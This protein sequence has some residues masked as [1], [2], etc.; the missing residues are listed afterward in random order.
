MPHPAKLMEVD[1]SF[2]LFSCPTS[3]PCSPHEKLCLFFLPKV[4]SFLIQYLV[5][6]FPWCEGSGCQTELRLRL[7]A[8]PQGVQSL[9]WRQENVRRL[10]FSPQLS[11]PPSQ[12]PTTYQCFL[13]GGLK[14]LMGSLFFSEGKFYNA[15]R[16]TKSKGK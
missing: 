8:W 5:V 12:R 16:K 15:V 1:M 11:P 13:H 3:S 7:R 14:H 2:M 4:L 6:G 9:F 10:Q